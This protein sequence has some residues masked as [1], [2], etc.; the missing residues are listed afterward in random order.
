MS[1][2]L[3]T[4]CLSK[5]KLPTLYAF[6]LSTRHVISYHRRK[7]V[8]LMLFVLQKSTLALNSIKHLQLFDFICFSIFLKLRLGWLVH[9]SLILP[10]LI[11]KGGHYIWNFPVL[12]KLYCYPQKRRRR[13]ATNSNCFSQISKYSNINF[14]K[15]GWLLCNLIYLSVL[16]VIWFI[17]AFSNLLFPC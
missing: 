2:P 11:L 14:T 7:Q 5:V 8:T 1:K 9:N 6:S 10:F 4:L 15:S 13:I 12:W 17:W 3:P 16:F